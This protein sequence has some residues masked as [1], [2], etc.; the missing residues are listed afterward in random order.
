VR[1]Q[2]TS[3]VSTPDPPLPWHSYRTLIACSS[4][5]CA[6]LNGINLI[7]YYAPLLFE[8]AGWFVVAACCSPT[9]LT[10]HTGSG[11]MRFS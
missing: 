4:Q 10:W 8:A 9:P 11:A 6:Q 3:H 1:A 7:S 2:L 5:A